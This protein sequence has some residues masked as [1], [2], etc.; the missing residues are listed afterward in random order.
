MRDVSMTSPQ[1]FRLLYF[2]EVC[3]VYTQER[4]RQKLG[5]S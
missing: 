4:A 1:I 2:R 3:G 5:G